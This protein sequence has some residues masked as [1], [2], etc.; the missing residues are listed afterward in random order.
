[1]RLKVADLA[2]REDATFAP[3]I[4][5]AV[6]VIEIAGPLDDGDV[7][8]QAARERD[9][10]AGRIVRRAELL[11]TRMG[12]QADLSRMLA[13]APWIGLALAALIA[14]AGL[15]L[16]GSVVGERHINVMVAL[17][18]L[19]GFHLLTLML[20]LVGLWL[21]IGGLNTSL[22]WLWFALTARV[23]GGK[24]GQAPVLLRAA[25]RL[26]IRARLLAWTFGLLSHALWSLS[27]IAALAALLFALAFRSYTLSWETTILEPG[28]FVRVVHG[29]GLLPGWIGF[30]VPDAA[31]ILAPQLAP[32]AGAA[33]SVANAAG[34]R[35]WALWLTGC[36]VVYGLA[37]RLLFAAWCA[38]VWQ[39]RMSGLRPD[40]HAPYYQKLRARF[41][42]LA[43]ATRIVSPDPGRA[44]SRAPQPLATNQTRDAL[45]VIGFELPP[46]TAWPPADLPA[47]ATMLRNDG[48]SSER[49]ALLEQ[50]AQARPRRVLVVC[51][52]NASPDR[53]TER[54]FRALLEHSGGCR[55]WLIAPRIHQSPEADVSNDGMTRV[56]GPYRWREWL[57][58]AGLDAIAVHTDLRRALEGW[59]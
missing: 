18:S 26:L 6:E 11:G 8:R 59:S 28:F 17:V 2:G 47:S 57:A 31:T 52:G 56:D 33:P 22:G 46:E 42:A 44:A 38:A 50:V 37:P 27:F 25:T 24:R 49:R 16:A 7:L 51:N 23:A 19:L 3:L 12:L 9:S 48:S 1:M 14:A 20:W 10:D 36:V 21:P 29:L 55:L 43:P 4:T 32:Q 39:R 40:G 54:L 34:Q 58:Q 35:A 45:F 13:W 5:E 53:G 30:P 15:G 41:D